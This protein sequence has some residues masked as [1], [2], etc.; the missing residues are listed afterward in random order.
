M[1]RP[2]ALPV[3]RYR[4]ILPYPSAKKGAVENGSATLFQISNDGGTNMLFYVKLQLK[5]DKMQEMMERSSKGEIPSPAE[6]ATIYCS[7]EKPGLG[8]TIFNVESR[9]QLDDILEK[10]KPY[11]EVYETAPI[12]TLAEFQAKM[13]AGI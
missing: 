1:Y 9:G 11:S 10:L 2:Q 3:Q 6:H 12:I 4:P 5:M 8:Y 13:A 7:S